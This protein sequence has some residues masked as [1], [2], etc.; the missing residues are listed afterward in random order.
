MENTTSSHKP[1]ISDLDAS[2]QAMRDAD[3]V[4]AAPAEPEPAAAEKQPVQGQDAADV[5]DAEDFEWLKGL[6]EEEKKRAIEEQMEL[7][8]EDYMDRHGLIPEEGVYYPR[9]LQAFA[10]LKD[11]IAFPAQT[12]RIVK[13]LKSLMYNTD[14]DEMLKPEMRDFFDAVISILDF[15][16]RNNESFM[17]V[18]KTGI[19]KEEFLEELQKPEYADKKIA[20]LYRD[21]NGNTVENPL[22][23]DTPIR[24]I[25]EAIKGRKE[26]RK[27]IR[28]TEIKSDLACVPN[29]LLIN[30]LAELIDAGRTWIKPLSTWKE[31]RQTQVEVSWLAQEDNVE[32]T[33]GKF[34]EADRHVFDALCV[35]FDN[36][37]FKQEATL[38]INQIY[39][40][41]TGNKNATLSPQQK[42]DVYSALH[43]LQ[44]IHIY[45]DATLEMKHRKKAPY[46]IN[47]PLLSIPAV[48]TLYST[49]YFT[50]AYPPLLKYSKITGQI[51]R[52]DRALLHVLECTRNGEGK[53]IFGK[54]VQTNERRRTING[55]FLRRI[56]IMN[57]GIKRANDKY[58]ADLKRRER[59]AKKNPGGGL[60]P[61]KYDW[62]PELQRIVIDEE[63]FAKFGIATASDKSKARAYVRDKLLPF[64]EAMGFIRRSSLITAGKSFRAVTIFPTEKPL[65]ITN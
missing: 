60:P 45:A 61:V 10:R 33:G 50:F 41:M 46:T 28:Q 12:D 43:R 19:S 2:I 22:E 48:E 36:L 54:P 63:F 37:D 29:C 27:R 32:V 1:Y 6:S 21:V 58:S 49:I 4:Q 62:Q 53:W 44:N 51:V 26:K 56:A 31:P 55:Y 13:P 8:R 57:N 52:Y 14:L 59:Q 7:D 42:A 11:V 65:K 24:R 64:Y 18:K 20:D 40:L 34:T 38:S 39:Q 9:D 17:P 16:R 47:G 15:Y 35:P 25:V 5:E 30:S 23:A 3:K